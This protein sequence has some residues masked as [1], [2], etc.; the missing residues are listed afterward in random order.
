MTDDGHHGHDDDYGRCLESLVE[1]FLYIDGQLDAKRSAEI[2]HHLTMCS[3]CYGRVQFEK[4]LRG[5]VKSKACGESPPA[6]LSVRVSAILRE[7]L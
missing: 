1:V 4:M 7:Q 2:D 6:S 5:Y 3:K